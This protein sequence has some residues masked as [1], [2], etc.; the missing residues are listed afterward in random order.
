VEEEGSIN[1][2]KFLRRSHRAWAHSCPQVQLAFQAE[3][4]LLSKLCYNPI[5][6]L[7]ITRRY[8]HASRGKQER[9]EHDSQR[10]TNGTRASRARQVP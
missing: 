7:C 10:T 3:V 2:F 4:E 1:F 6:G 9:H 8:A 5:E